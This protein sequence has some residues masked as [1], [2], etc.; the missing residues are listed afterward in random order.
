MKLNNIII[1]LQ[2]FLDGILDFIV[3]EV[4]IEEWQEPLFLLR[5]VNSLKKL[6]LI[7]QI[8]NTIVVS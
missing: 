6:W 4:M 3:F 8:F 5:I 7:P 1:L 2:I